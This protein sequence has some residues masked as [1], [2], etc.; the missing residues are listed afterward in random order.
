[1]F[2]DTDTILKDQELTMMARNHVIDIV[3][4]DY[5]VSTNQYLEKDPLHFEANGEEPVLYFLRTLWS[6]LFTF[7]GE[8]TIN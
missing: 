6:F 4:W 8:K 1:M 5:P 3:R 2:I 7:K